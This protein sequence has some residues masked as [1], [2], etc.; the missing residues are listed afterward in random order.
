MS[1][2]VTLD[3]LDLAALLCSRVCHDLIS[4][5]GA[6]VNGLEVLEEEGDAETK[7]FAIELIKKSARTASARLQFCRIA[8]GAAGSAGAQIDTGDAESMARGFM[9]DN[10]V[11]LTWNLPRTLLPKNRVKLLLNMLIVAGGTIPRGGTLTIDPVGSGETTGFRITAA[12]LN[13]RIPPAVVDLLEG[14]PENGT[15]DAHAIQPFYTG[16]LA[17]ACGVGIG[18]AMEG[19]AVIVA[20]R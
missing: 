8:F 9:E 11:K 17:R 16:L 19:E 14:S 20:T 18:L 3:S 6:I 10:K 12:G 1:G 4:P 7:A 5:T 13:A 2:P 15:V